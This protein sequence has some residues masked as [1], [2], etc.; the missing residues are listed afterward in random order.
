MVGAQIEATFTEGADVAT[1][2]L[3]LDSMV[4]VMLQ[5]NIASTDVIRHGLLAHHRMSDKHKGWAQCLL[6]I[7]ELEIDH[8]MFMTSRVVITNLNPDNV[9]AAL[10][11]MDQR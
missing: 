10:V 9:R 2:D 1:L 4:H 7:P 5:T 8:P 11:H 6:V 3:G